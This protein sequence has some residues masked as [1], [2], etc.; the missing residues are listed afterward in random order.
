MYIYLQCRYLIPAPVNRMSV[1]AWLYKNTMDSMSKIKAKHINDLHRLQIKASFS[2]EVSHAFMSMKTWWST[3]LWSCNMPGLPTHL[4]QELNVSTVP[5]LQVTLRK[6][7]WHVPL[8]SRVCLLLHIELKW[9]FIMNEKKEN[10]G[11]NGGGSKYLI[12][13]LFSDKTNME[14]I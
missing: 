4:V 6:E 13:E 11:L 9:W 5:I 1:S 12:T 8:H 3:G 7:Y 14:S 10:G 2:Y